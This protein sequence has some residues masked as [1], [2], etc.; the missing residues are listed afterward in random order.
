MS[1]QKYTEAW[2][3]SDISALLEFHHDDYELVSHSTG[4]VKKMDDID[5]DQMISW[6]LVA[7][8]EKHRCFYENDDII[9]EHQK[10]GSESG[11]REALILVHLLK[12]GLL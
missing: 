6:S 12:D 3:V 2:N 11:D 10:I 1:F 8:V 5:W 9:V 4:E 7:K